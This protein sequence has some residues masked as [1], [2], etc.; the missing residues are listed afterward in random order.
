MSKLEAIHTIADT[1]TEIDVA[2]GS[3]L[4]KDPD[5]VRLDD[6][7]LLLDDRQTQLSK[8]VFDENTKRSR[9]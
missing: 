6:L 7:R 8:A 1:I 3:L 2:R 9:R 4:P 5:R